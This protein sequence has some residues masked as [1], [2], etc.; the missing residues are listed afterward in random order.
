MV[1]LFTSVYWSGA[2]VR[3]RPQQDG[4][5]SSPKR[6]SRP[7]ALWGVRQFLDTI[8]MRTTSGRVK[9]PIH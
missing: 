4:G 5:V 7:V 3:R 1:R 6:Q 2:K 9:S 8:T